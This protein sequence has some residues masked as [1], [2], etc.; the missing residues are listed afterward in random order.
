MLC[1]FSFTIAVNSLA[2]EKKCPL[3]QEVMGVKSPIP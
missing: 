3:A 1:P 2:T